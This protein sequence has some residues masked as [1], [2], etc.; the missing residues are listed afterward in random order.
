MKMINILLLTMALTSITTYAN[1]D[2]IVL[3]NY[4]RAVTT[5][6]AQNILSCFC[7][8]A[9]LES[10]SKTYIGKEQ[11]RS[12]YEEGLLQCTKFF[13]MA[14]ERAY[15]KNSIA[16]EIGLNCDGQI[17][18]VGDFFKFSNNKISRLH[19]YARK[20]MVNIQFRM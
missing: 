4:F 15:G 14:G 8:D 16:V 10:D 11:I 18:R 9:I 17:N 19:V 2:D 1:K 7:D 12:F 3:D 5:R 13:P 20:K 6:S